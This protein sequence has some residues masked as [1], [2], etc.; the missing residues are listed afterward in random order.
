MTISDPDH[1]ALLVER[2]TAVEGC[3]IL[4]AEAPRLAAGRCPMK[5]LRINYR[6]AGLLL[7]SRSGDGTLR[8]LLGRRVHNPG[9]GLWS[10]PG[11]EAELREGFR[12]RIAGLAIYDESYRGAALRE[13][14]EEI[15]LWPG[16]PDWPGEGEI[17][18]VWS[19]RSFVFDWSSY[20]WLVE[21]P[22]LSP[23]TCPGV[24]PCVEFDALRWFT[25]EELRRFGELRGLGEP[26]DRPARL[27]PGVR[28]AVE[29]AARKFA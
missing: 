1:E 13:A 12:R 16:A 24:K 10:I 15:R 27:H 20:A 9:R 23:P 7:V 17:V 21:N 5:R 2:F 18:P 4:N 25:V 8:F 29:R 28:S 26:Q 6:G 3:A 11:G 14:R 22:G 19:V